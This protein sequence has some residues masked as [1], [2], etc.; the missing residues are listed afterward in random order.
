MP[1]RVLSFILSL[2]L[3]WSGFSTQEQPS[4]VALPAQEQAYVSA[5][6]ASSDIAHGTVNDP[7]LD[8][9]SFQA[10]PLNEGWGLLPAQLSSNGTTL[11]M[12]QP[13]RFESAAL[14]APYLNGPLRPPRA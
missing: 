6:D 1:Q 14:C 8:D 11:T 2:V 10:D 13:R 12:L 7:H 4:A 9:H 3:L 5:V